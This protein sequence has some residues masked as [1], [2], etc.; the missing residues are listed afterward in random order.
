MNYGFRINLTINS[1][2]YPSTTEE[3][4]MFKIGTFET[5]NKTVL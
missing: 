5:W 2:I 3:T 1:V 4:T